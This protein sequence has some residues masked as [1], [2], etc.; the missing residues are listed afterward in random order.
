MKQLLKDSDFWQPS[1]NQ[2]KI[3][4]KPRKSCQKQQ[5]YQVKKQKQNTIALAK[6]IESETVQCSWQ[7]KNTTESIKKNLILQFGFVA[8][9]TLSTRHNASN[10]LATTPTWYYFS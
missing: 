7:K 8:D 1:S 2:M 6:Q 10:T 4:Q 5:W 9:P 3:L